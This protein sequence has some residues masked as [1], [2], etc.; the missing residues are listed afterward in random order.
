[1]IYEWKKLELTYLSERI[2]GPKVVQIACRSA[3]QKRG[4]CWIANWQFY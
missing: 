3:P 1:M 2:C 4:L